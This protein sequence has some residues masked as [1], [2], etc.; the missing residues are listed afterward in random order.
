MK[1]VQFSV[2][3]ILMIFSFTVLAQNN[4]KK[5]NMHYEQKNA[6]VATKKEHIT[7]IHGLEL[8]DNYFWMR[9]KEN[10]ELLAHL[11]AE[12]AFTEKTLEGTKAFQ[13]K[14]FNEIKG[15]IKEDDESVPYKD[16]NYFYY[17]RYEK[18]GE[19]ALYCRKKGDL[20]GTE[21]IVLNGNEMGKGLA[22]FSIGGY[23]IADNEQIV[24]YGVDTVSRRNYTVKFK[25]LTTGEI[26]KDEIVNTEGGSYAWG[27]DNKTFYYIL[28]DQKTLLGYQ[29]WRHTLGADNKTDELVFEEKDNEFYLG[30]FKDKSKKYIW[31]VSS[32]GGVADEWQLLPASDAKAKFTV[33]SPR[34]NGHEYSVGYFKNKFYIK[35][36][37]NKATNY[38]LMEVAEKD[39]ANQKLW[40]EVLPHRA[41]VFLDNFEIFA[42]HLVIQER[43]N[44]LMNVVIVDQK[45]GKKHN[46]NF[47]EPAYTAYISTNPEFETNIVR[48][49]YTSM[50][51]PGSTF[52]YNMDTKEQILKKQQEIPGG[53]DKTQYV[54]ERLWATARDGVKVPISLV[55]KKGTKLDGTAPLFQYAYGSYGNSIDPYFSV[56]RL[57]L[58]NRGFVFAICHI[59]GG[60]E[61]GRNWYENGKMGKK[62]NTF[63]DF[64]DCSKFLVGKKYTSNDRLFANGGSAGGLLMGAIANMS[65]QSYKAVIANVPFV[66][67]INTMLDET[68]PLTTGEWLEWGNPKI[69]KEFDYMM[70]YSPYDNVKAQAYPNMF[71]LTGFHDSQ[72]QYWEPAKWVAKLRELKTDNNIL[73]FD[74]N[75]DAGHGGAS[76]RFNSIKELAKEY[77]FVLDLM[78]IKE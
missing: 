21:E 61:M 36:N 37:I 51:T 30:L 14:L 47:G 6:P 5:I 72:V 50:T 31:A 70:K 74:C 76:G 17:T 11:K 60:Q 77:A 52:D 35:T 58:L 3:A 43:K 32:H 53:Y 9:E 45:T 41:D 66:D 1:K 22:Y 23:E 49:S 12:N 64:I 62:L 27:T 55:Y 69:K 34:K 56:A 71:V 16:G 33:F 25:N 59:R 40:K 38:K 44:G 10:P 78:G 57:S 20:N 48:Y 65:P 8:K 63:Y 2:F 39:F 46:L 28:K 73:M 24:A 7:P 26:Y 13:E 29:I 19:Y 15:R 54:T 42:N 18:G 67:V 4:V 68:I 75:M